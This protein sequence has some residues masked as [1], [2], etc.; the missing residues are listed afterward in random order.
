MSRSVDRSPE[1]PLRDAGVVGNVY[2]K[3]RTRNPI[4]RLLMRGFLDAVT[5]LYSRA[6]PRTVLEVGCGEGLLAQHLVTHGFRPD[7]FEA[8]DVDTSRIAP[9]L[10]PIIEVRRASAYELPYDDD[11]FDL[12]VCC[13]VLEHLERPADAL[14]ELARVARTSVLVST[15]W[16]PVWRV[17]NVLRG[18]Y[19]RDLGNTPGHIQHFTRA[20]LERLAGTRLRILAR[21]RPLPWTILLGEPLG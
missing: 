18:R 10:D 1:E 19:L 20:E 5:E 11:A 4:A 8:T 21:R 16:E 17:L 7:R 2:D 13:E 3:Y 6:R 9:G 12:V 15:P 14:K